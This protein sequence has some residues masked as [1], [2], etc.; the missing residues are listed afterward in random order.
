MST[1]SELHAKYNAAVKRFKDTEKAEAAAEEER[2]KKRALAR[3]TQEGTKEHY[4]TWAKYWNAEVV[5][6]EK[7]E[8]KYAAEYEKDSCYVDWMKHKHGVDSTEAQIAQHRAELARKREFVC[9]EGSPF[10]IKWY[11]LHYTALCVYYQLR[12]EGYDNIAD[13]LWRA[14]EVYYNRIKEERNVK[15]FSEAWH[16]ALRSLNTWQSSRYREEWDK[17][18]QWCDSQLAKWNEFKPK[19]E[20]YAKE[21]QDKI[22][23]CAKNSL[24]TYAIVNDF[25]PGVLK[26]ELGQKDQEIGGLHD[27]PGKLDA[28]VGEMR[29]WFKSLIH[30]NQA[31]INWQCKQ[32][33]EFEA[34]A[35]TTVEQEWQNWSEKMTSSHINLVNWIQERIAEMTALE[36]EEATTRNKYNHEFNDSVQN[37]DNRRFALKEMLSGWILD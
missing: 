3:K 34:F 28:T 12:A 2:D 15:P 27:I 7:I 23:E 20:P 26:D 33:E 14:N 32:L 18:K 5:L 21:L 35:R 22:C 29:T 31:S 17:A 11:K 24:N 1:A 30:M 8:Q 16:A 10:W 9:T 25:E 6:L 37:I 36:E 19:G 4:L 13:E